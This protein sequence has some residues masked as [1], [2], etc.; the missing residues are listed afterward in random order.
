MGFLAAY[1]LG[2]GFWAA[3]DRAKFFE[4][5]S[6]GCLV[7]AVFAAY[8]LRGNFSS[9]RKWSGLSFPMCLKNKKI[10]ICGLNFGIFV[11]YLRERH[12]KKIF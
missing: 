8:Q 11:A 4:K 10:F 1:Q 9:P 7:F 12:F 2:D 5:F 6:I 3:V